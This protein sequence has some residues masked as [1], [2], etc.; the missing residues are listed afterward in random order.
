VYNTL[1]ALADHIRDDAE[2]LSGYIAAETGACQ[3]WGLEF[4]YGQ[5]GE[6]PRLSINIDKVN[7]D[8]S[9]AKYDIR[10]K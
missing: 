3:D 7:N 8:F 10:L 2:D 5:Y 1:I 6:H 9:N 4:T